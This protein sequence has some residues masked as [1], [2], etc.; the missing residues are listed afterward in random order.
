MRVF[1]ALDSVFICPSHKYLYYTAKSS[2]KQDFFKIFLIK[3]IPQL[4][5]IPNKERLNNIALLLR[6]IML[7]GAEHGIEI[8]LKEYFFKCLVSRTTIYYTG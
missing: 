3:K 4:R 2:T 8:E 7:C 6:G 5:G 1:S